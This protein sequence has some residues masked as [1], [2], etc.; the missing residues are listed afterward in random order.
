MAFM[1]FTSV[2]V[3]PFDSEIFMATFRCSPSFLFQLIPATSPG[4][5]HV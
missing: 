3:S 4:V 2:A 1:A 5:F